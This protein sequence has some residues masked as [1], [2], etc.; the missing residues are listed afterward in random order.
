MGVPH[1]ALDAYLLWMDSKENA[2]PVLLR[3]VRYI[4]LVGIALLTWRFSSELFWFLFF[5][6]AVYHFGTSDEHPAVLGAIF[7][8][9][10][11]RFLWEFNRGLVLVFAPAA[12]HS[13]K[14][15]GY[16]NTATSF[17]FAV[18]FVR[19]APFLCGYGLLIYLW[20]SLRGAM[21][22]QLT[23][24]RWLILKH[25]F[26]LV[27]F[28]LLFKVSDPLV[29]FTLYFC[30]HHSLTHWFRVVS[31][32]KSPII[33]FVAVGILFTLPVIPL[34]FWTQDKISNG[35][36]ATEMVTACF[37]VIAALT[38]PHLKVVQ[39][40]HEKLKQSFRR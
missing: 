8:H 30:C 22:A 25:L 9:S 33:Q 18:G 23:S 14:I 2:Y 40:Q 27:V 4:G 21:K 39:T 16:L 36:E 20:T 13:E 12:F 5:L 32:K 7:P 10:L 26:S 11:S 17:E 29:G 3:L 35:M 6:S 28:I 31:N 15:F 38:F 34:L 24:H 1:G 37:V 19:V